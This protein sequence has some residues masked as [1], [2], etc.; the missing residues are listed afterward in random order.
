MLESHYSFEFMFAQVDCT[1]DKKQVFKL[2]A[3]W[4]AS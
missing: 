1:W 2:N 4:E 3:L